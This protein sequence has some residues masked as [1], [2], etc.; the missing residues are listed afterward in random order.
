MLCLRVSLVNYIGPVFKVRCPARASRVRPAFAL[1][2]RFCWVL[3]MWWHLAVIILRGRVFGAGRRRSSAALLPAAPALPTARTPAGPPAEP[4]PRHAGSSGP[5]WTWIPP[6]PPLP[7]PWTPSGL[8]LTS[9]FTSL[10]ADTSGVS[11]TGQ[12]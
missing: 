3:A 8:A 12:T 11:I 4:R 2:D 5:R 7:P 9:L 10:W 1:F 6:A